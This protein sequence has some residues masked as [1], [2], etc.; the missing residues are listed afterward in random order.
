MKDL[1][2]RLYHGDGRLAAELIARGA[3]SRQDVTE[4][5]RAAGRPSASMMRGTR[6]R[7]E[8][9][10]A[11]VLPVC[12]KFFGSRRYPAGTFDPGFIPAL[13]HC[14][15]QLAIHAVINAGLTDRELEQLNK[16]TS[17]Q[18]DGHLL[19]Q[20]RVAIEIEIDRRKHDGRRGGGNRVA[21]QLG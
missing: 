17:L 5:V 11:I 9:K 19:R 12:E 13:A 7:I 8:K 3:F 16:L 15:R 1:I 2:R 6:D 21:T 18:T 4:F 14:D 20:L 10:R